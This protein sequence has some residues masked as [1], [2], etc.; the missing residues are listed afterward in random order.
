MA[1]MTDISPAGAQHSVE[2][3]HSLKP[4]HVTMI[5]LGGVVGAGLFI[6]ASAAIRIGGPG[7]LFVY[8]L[9]G[10]QVLLNMR[11]LGEMAAA[12][13]RRG[14]FATYIALS[15]GPWAGFVVRWLYWYCQLFTIGAETVAGAKLLQQLGFPGEIWSI[16]LGLVALLTLVN[17]VSVRA[18][19]ELEFGLASLKIGAMVLFIA[20]GLAFIGLNTSHAVTTVSGHG[21]VFPNGIAG[22]VAAIPIVIFSMFGSEMATIA[23]A[24]SND[25]AGNIVRAGRTVAL[26]VV[27]FYVATIGVIVAIVPWTSVTVGL[28][29]FKTALDAIGI[30]GSGLIMSVIV[31]IAVL[32][33][34][35]SSIYVS[36]RMLYELGRNGDGPRFLSY[37]AAN[38]TPIIGVL[39]ACGAGATATLGQIWARQDVFTLLAS[40]TGAIAL[41]IGVLSAVAQIRQRRRLEAAGVELPVKMWLFPWLS[42]ALILGMLGILV[43]LAMSAEQRLAMILSVI[44]IAIVLGGAA[45]R[46]W[47]GDTFRQD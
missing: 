20:I 29:P 40:S 16:G 41:F 45:R 39:L 15:L 30:P 32:S 33:C 3:G 2:L 8:A 12:L 31:F 1:G 7:V 6:G 36:S 23:A 34:L 11:I 47:R 42:Y 4:R 17:A 28:S 19:G 44:A 46:Q 27:L 35:N 14:S 5:S 25:P 18:Y 37:T 38:Q 22:L 10:I 9:C 43:I 13:P 21:G 24:E 26:R